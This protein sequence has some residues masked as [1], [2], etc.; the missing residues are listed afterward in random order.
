MGGARALGNAGAGA[1]GLLGG[2][3]WDTAEREVCERARKRELCWWR[4]LVG[5]LKLVFG[6]FGAFYFWFC[7]F[8]K[9]KALRLCFWAS[10]G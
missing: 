7:G 6:S 1:R 10:R 4:F 9:S 2:W 3:P 5:V 8:K